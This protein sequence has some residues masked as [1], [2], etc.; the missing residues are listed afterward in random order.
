MKIKLKSHN[1]RRNSATREKKPK[2]KEPKL[3]TKFEPKRSRSQSC[4]IYWHLMRKTMPKLKTKFE[5]K[6]NWSHS[7]SSN[8]Q[9]LRKLKLIYKS[10]PKLPWKTPLS[11]SHKVKNR[12][13]TN[14][15]A[16]KHLPPNQNLIAASTERNTYS[17]LAYQVRWATMMLTI[18]LALVNS[19]ISSRMSL[20][21]TWSKWW[22][23]I[24]SR[25]LYWLPD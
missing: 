18:R 16:S 21:N 9:L 3:K 4:G 7:C 8:W 20:S 19:A 22:L 2:K 11:L 15:K 6:I 5:P 12:A 13:K 1:C 14:P 25:R 17:L 23:V 24:L 10:N